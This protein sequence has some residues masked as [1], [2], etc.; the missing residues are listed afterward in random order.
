[1]SENNHQKA[2]LY[3]DDTACAIEPGQPEQVYRLVLLGAPGVGKGTQAELLSHRL[4]ACHLSTGDVFRAQKSQP[5]GERTPP[6]ESALKAMSR[7]DLVPDLTVMGMVRERLRCLRCR[8]GFLLDGFP[9]TIIQAETLESLLKAE[10][11]ALT[12]VISYDLAVEKIVERLS[13]RRTC[14]GCKAIFH[15]TGC[16]PKMD[17]ICDHCGATLYQR[18]DDWPKSIAV[19][20]EAYEKSTK[21]LIDFY[22]E[23][24]LLIS[25]SAVDSPEETCRFTL[26]ALNALGAAGVAFSNKFCGFSVEND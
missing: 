16:P 3:G 17:G 24:R 25:I 5:E 23:R 19:R 12:A 21:P 8:G 11:L 1:M 4:G 20:I 26:N 7:G 9:R 2:W 18:E 14:S 13:G 22:R 6:L 10:G 15:M